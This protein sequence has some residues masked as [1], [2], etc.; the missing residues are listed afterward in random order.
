MRIILCLVLLLTTV[1]SPKPQ[2]ELLHNAMSAN[3]D[4]SQAIK[5]QH[6]K[7]AEVACDK[8]ALLLQD[9]IVAESKK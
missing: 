9:C 3:Y 8:M 6:W 2:I 5:K 4:C 7:E 1:P